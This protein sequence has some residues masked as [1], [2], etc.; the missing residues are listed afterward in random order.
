MPS[1]SLL[2][3]LLLP[4]SFCI[5]NTKINV[6]AKREQE[7]GLLCFMKTPNQKYSKKPLNSKLQQP[8]EKSGP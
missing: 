7:L 8:A 1:S 6:N 5:L 4:P 3:H 2:H